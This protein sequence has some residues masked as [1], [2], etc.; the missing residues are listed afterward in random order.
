MFDIIRKK[1]PSSQSTKLPAGLN[2]SNLIGT[3]C[4]SQAMISF[5]A[6]GVVV[7][8]NP[9]FLS[10]MGYSL[11]EIVGTH[12]SKFVDKKFAASPKY[13]EFWDKLNHGVYQSGI[14]KRHTKSGDVVWLQ[15]VYL[16]Q[17]GSDGKLERVVKFATDY[18]ETQNRTV[19]ALGK[20]AAMDESQAVIE[21]ELD[22]TIITAN[23]NFLSTVG[24]E[25]SEIQGKHHSIFV[26]PAYSKSPKYAEFWDK[27]RA[28]EHLTSEYRR[29]GN[30]GKE[31]WLQASYTPILDADGT[32]VKV[33]K[34]ATD[35]TAQKLKNADFEGKI[36]ALNKAQAVIE[37]ELDGT[38]IAAN[39]NFL[40][41][42]GY[43]LEEIVGKH[44]SIFVDGAYK[45][46]IEYKAFWIALGKGE[47]RSGEYQRVG[48][49]G[50]EIWLQATYNPIFD[51]SGKPF[52][53]VKFASDITSM[54]LARKERERVG[55]QVDKNL[56]EIVTSVGTA[57]ERAGLAASAST[58]TE[59]MVQTVASAAEELNASFREIAE[60]VA[61]AR[62][63][64]DKTSGETRAADKSTKTLSE[65]AEAMNKI[66]VLIED[67]ASQINL[68][69]L[70]ATIESARAG[71]AGKGFAVVASEVKNLATQVAT[72]TG[73]ISDEITR[74]QDVSSEVVER[75]VGINSAVG[76]LQGSVTGIAGAIEEQSVVTQEIS[77]NMQ[78][79]AGAVAEINENLNDLSHNINSANNL[80]N[81]GI[82]LYRRLE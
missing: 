82:D 78:T 81:E 49:G 4:A 10:L 23:K 14:F 46:S 61:L 60:S 43:S 66:V 63:A 57:N 56:D 21:F 19:D 39:Q 33:V 35:I 26:D 59:A 77:S 9:T 68:L 80:A 18:S 70:N 67:I 13:R 42:V 12:H 48:N 31:I 47:F 76:D 22:G 79:A 73:Q 64:V 50:K 7:D 11:E 20:A 74:M 8:A 24:Y 30:A 41:A 25:L 71:E 75:L 5:D 40:E 51:P 53:V 16:P 2:A 29:I 58:E 32:P 45:G 15:A 38:I 37:F 44:H 62:N 65:A 54:V 36:E 28:G 27:L 52:K 6:N 72:A 1:P 34:F 17:M 69:A 55:A 3:M